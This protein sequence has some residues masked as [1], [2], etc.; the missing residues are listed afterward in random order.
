MESPI[1]NFS[2]IYTNGVQKLKL[3]LMAATVTVSM[4]IDNTLYAQD[5]TSDIDKIFS[6]ATPATPGC[7]CAV[8]QHGKVMVN[9]AY[10]SADLERDVPINTNTLF[11][12]GSLQKQFVAAAALLLVEEGRLSLAD[13]VRKYIPELPDYGHKITI[14]HLL[15]HTSGIRDWNGLMPF[16][17]GKENAWTLIMRQR[18]LNSIPGEEWFYSNSGFVLMK[19]IIA[20]ISGMSFIEFTRKRIFDTLG[21]KS[22]AFRE[23]LRDVLKNRAL[24]YDKDDGRWKM[25][26]LP[27]N[28]RGT[29]ALFTTASDLLIWNDALT[30]GRL[31][32]LVNGKL[33]EQ[34]TLNNGRKLD[35][36]RGIFFGTYRSVKEVYYTGSADGYKSWLGR[37]P[38]HGLSIAIL[39]N[40][41]DG[42][43][44]TAF[45][46]RVFDLFVPNAPA[47]Q[48]NVP[49][50]VA[51]SALPDLGSKAGLYFSERTGE[52]L[53]LV[54][55]RARLRIAAGPGLVP[56][57][58][59]RFKRFGALVQFMSQDAFEIQFLSH[60]QFELKSME[61]KITRYRRARPYTPTP[62]EL[63]AFAGRYESDE[64]GTVFQVMAAE[65]GLVIRLE[66]EP[67]KSLEVKP[68]D[69]NTFQIARMIIRFRRDKSGKVVG[70]EYSNPAL[71][72]IP[73]T[74][75]SE[76]T[77][78][79]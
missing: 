43:D 23:D 40:S 7:A 41:G 44:R 46:H 60:D 30:N 12:A 78:R 56:V 1:T 73:F 51:D 34:T 70:L 15:T 61:G 67:A 63:K 49:P 11:D 69:P 58:K 26:M 36:S 55:D 79:R 76:E 50:P 19:E 74:R 16:T 53:Q 47:A 68:V 54:V 32:K 45:A 29:S 4:L 2:K 20:R 75:L 64:I 27:D 31:G 17:A 42:T 3:V 22:T 38:E 57:S 52:P 13:D 39:C 37:Y 71:R 33:H 10:G 8:S 48:S 77:G 35:H 65:N 6:W 66:H 5:K 21:M 62:S 59:D 18:G 24:A 9:R 28:N 72:N 25:A 14:D